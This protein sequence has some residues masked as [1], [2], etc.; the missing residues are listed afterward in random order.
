M[1]NKKK[2]FTLVELLV[3]IAI[4][5]ILA[6]VSVVGYLAFTEKAK[7]SNDQTTIKMIN[8]NLM[9]ASIEEKPKTAGEAIVLLN[10][11]GFTK[12]KL[13]SY[14]NGYHYAYD[15]DNNI[16][17]LYDDNDKIVYPDS[18]ETTNSIWALYRNQD[19]DSIAGV[20]NYV[21]VEAID[22]QVVFNK[23]FISSNTYNLDLNNF[24]IDVAGSNN[25]TVSNGSVE[26]NS[27]FNV[28]DGVVEQVI[29]E[30]GK[31]VDLVSVGE[32]N[33]EI[34]GYVFDMNN[35]SAKNVLYNIKDSYD[36]AT[37]T[38]RNCKF[39]GQYEANQD[40]PFNLH[41]SEINPNTK[42]VVEN[43]TFTNFTKW[44][45][46]IHPEINC[47]IKN[48]TFINTGRGINVQDNNSNESPIK[49]VLIEGN[50][51]VLRSDSENK[52]R[53]LQIA[54]FSNDKVKSSGIDNVIL[55]NNNTIE[56]AYAVVNIHESLIHSKVDGGNTYTV[57]DWDDDVYTKL[58]SFDNNLVSN[59]IITVAPDVAKFESTNE[60]NLVNK[61]VNYYKGIFN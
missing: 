43:C 1:K 24:Y 6:A 54:D 44:S 18:R 22:N 4:L 48:N 37:I 53:A 23:V 46:A 59:D 39:V 7:L 10:T 25:I 52:N 38:I 57:K 13:V 15:L 61:F 50:T 27:G 31:N 29:L 8:D 28:G 49:Q 36:G 9:A 12:D 32:N 41:L 19:T 35:V 55:F 47:E 21:A 20:S 40:A 60:Q 34:N 3:V 16:F 33:Y 11:L 30:S 17:V 58:A 42:I 26:E 14:S 45:L 51:F 2:G 56:S 5:A